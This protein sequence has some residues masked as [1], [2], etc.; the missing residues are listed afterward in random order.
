MTSSKA[1][2]LD[3]TRQIQA[4][5]EQTRVHWLDQKAADF[6]EQFIAPLTHDVHTA[7]RAIDELDK[8]LHHV[9]ADCE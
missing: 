8:L 7:L 5:W 1:K 6:E 4:R 2:L 9:H 3:A